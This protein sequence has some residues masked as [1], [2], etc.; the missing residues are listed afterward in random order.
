MAGTGYHPEGHH[1]APYKG[2]LPYQWICLNCAVVTNNP[3]LADEY[4]CIDDC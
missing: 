2:T 4:E 1:W 3:D